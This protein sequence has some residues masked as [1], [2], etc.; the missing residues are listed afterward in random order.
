MRSCGR[1]GVAVMEQKAGAGNKR[2]AGG[3]FIDG[4][5]ACRNS[6]LTLCC[7]QAAAKALVA[8]RRSH[9][10]LV[11]MQSSVMPVRAPGMR[12]PATPLLGAVNPT[13]PTP[14]VRG[15]KWQVASGLG[16]VAIVQLHANRLKCA[17]DTCAAQQKADL[18]SH[19]STRSPALST[20]LAQ[21]YSYMRPTPLPRRVPKARLYSRLTIPPAISYGRSSVELMATAERAAD[22]HVL[23]AAV[24][25][26]RPLAHLAVVLLHLC[27]ALS[28]W[29]GLVR[30]P[31][32]CTTTSPRGFARFGCPAG[33]RAFALLYRRW[34]RV[35]R[36]NSWP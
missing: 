5:R 17:V 23:A 28:G 32:P 36:V 18:S 16:A 13:P 9:A 4:Q 14:S 3:G 21:N 10:P 24:S 2:G 26:P 8:P 25:L 19:Y 11:V 20:L 22:L 30:D 35:L 6:R 34:A 31:W 33:A 27:V 12:G 15:E 7:V 1:I 29:G